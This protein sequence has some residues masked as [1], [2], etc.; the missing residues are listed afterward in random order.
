[1]KA[2]FSRWHCLEW[3]EKLLV[4]VTSPITVPMFIVIT[5]STGVVAG[6]IYFCDLVFGD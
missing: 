1:M 3:W 4:I 2:F 5:I 6:V